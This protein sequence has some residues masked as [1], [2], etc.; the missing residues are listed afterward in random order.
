MDLFLGFSM[1]EPLNLERS[2]FSFA[3]VAT[4][5]KLRAISLPLKAVEV[6]V[7]CKMCSL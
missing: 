2:L 7:P 5:V 6:K 4:S 1:D 3:F